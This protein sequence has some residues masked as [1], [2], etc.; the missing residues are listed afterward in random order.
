MRLSKRAR[1]VLPAAVVAAVLAS[2]CGGG[3]TSGPSKDKVRSTT[4]ADVLA[5]LRTHNVAVKG[6]ITCDGQAPGVIDCHGTTTDGKDIQATLVASTS[7]LSCT[8]PLV[9]NV[10][11]TQLD[12][13]PDE[14]C[15]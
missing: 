2:G 5:V 3:G 12:S 8:G 11:K 6:S 1:L 7:G 15:S 13:L 4:A 10:D 9:V 14:K